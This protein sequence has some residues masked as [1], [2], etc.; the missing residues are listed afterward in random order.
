VCVCV[1]LSLVPRLPPFFVLQFAFSI[2]H[3]SGRAPLPVPCIILNTNRR[4][5]NR[6][7]LGTRLC[8]TLVKA[9][10]TLLTDCLNLSINVILKKEY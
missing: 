5:K 1:S 9:H 3:G 8:V 4:T 2:V 6:G 7:G 10:H